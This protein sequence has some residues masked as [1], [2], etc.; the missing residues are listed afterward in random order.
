P[1]THIA[2]FTSTYNDNDF[3]GAVFRVEQSISTK[4]PRNGVPPLAGPRAGNFPETRDFA[5]N[6]KRE[7]MVW[8]SMIG[9]DY[10][11]ALNIP[12]APKWPSP[13]NPLFGQDQWLLSMQFFDE[14]YSHYDHQIGLGDSVTDREQQF[15]PL[16]TFVATGFFVQQRLRPWI[17]TG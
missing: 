6:G 10:L 11:R 12:G 4:E 8:R 7:T 9:F 3:T 15:N 13:L 5:T 2:G 14:Y 1:W 17:A 16:A